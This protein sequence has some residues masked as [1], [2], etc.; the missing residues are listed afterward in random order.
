M[1]PFEIDGACRVSENTHCVTVLL[2]AGEYILCV[3]SITAM[4]IM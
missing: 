4:F 3:G 2:Q 1:Q